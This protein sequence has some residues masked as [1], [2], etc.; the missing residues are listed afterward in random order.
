MDYKTIRHTTDI[1]AIGGGIGGLVSGIMAAEA[2]AKVLIVD[3]ATAGGGG[4]ASRAGNGVLS[5][6]KDKE[7]IDRYV[8]YHVRNIGKYIEDQEAAENVASVIY[9][10][11]STMKNWGVKLTTDEE[12]NVAAFPTPGDV[13]WEMTGIEMNCNLSMRNKAKR[14][15]VEFL[16]FVQITGLLKDGE[17]IAGAVGYSI[18][19]GSF[20][21]IQAKTVIVSGGGCQ[22][23]NVAMFIGCGEGTK[24]AFDAGA[25]MRN[26]E[27]GNSYEVY[28]VDKGNT[29]Y[30]TYPFVHNA[31][32]ENLWDKYVKW[33]APG[34][35]AAFWRGFSEEYLAGNGP[36]YV[37]MKEFM[38]A[39]ENDTDWKYMGTSIGFEEQK[40]TVGARFFP[41]KLKY[42]KLFEEREAE[43]VQLT[44]KPEVKIAFHG[45]AGPVMV[46]HDFQSTVPGLYVIGIDSW[47]GSAVGGA[48]GHPGMQKGNGIGHAAFTAY[49]CAPKAVAY[50]EGVE[51]PKVSEVQV[52]ELKAKTY[53]AY[54]NA[55]GLD[56]HELI[57]QIQDCI[58]PVKISC[59]RE[60]NRMIAALDEI[61]KIRKELLPQM[62]VDN[63]HDL[64]VAHE[65]AAMAEVA[66]MVLRAAIIRKESRGTHIRQDYPEMDN[67]NWLKWIIIENDNGE[68]KLSTQDIPIEKYPYR[69]DNA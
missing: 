18:L 56:P 39:L 19:D 7:V 29:I 37:D 50:A 62:K 28:S 22:F 33:D 52:E 57:E 53:A 61:V 55:E 42:S 66:E 49:I 32:G 20:H 67:E 54:E 5:I 35:D 43:Y 12:G 25:K 21:I 38:Q 60:E 1:L 40:G 24:L 26:A 46:D 23:K 6:K 58:T 3:K 41:D 30:G 45:N 8:E 11:L 2:G 69:P 9:D 63:Y 13:P 59:L 64:K 14:A 27:F 15:G 4:G 51:L 65:V 68:M 47:N 16:E 48:V 10:T 34:P 36:M 17:R 44:D 31:K